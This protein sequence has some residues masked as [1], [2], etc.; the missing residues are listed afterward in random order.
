MRPDHER[1]APTHTRGAAPPTGSVYIYS[2][3]WRGSSGVRESR[4]LT[5][6]GSDN[7]L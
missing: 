6:K 4:I 3:Y 1:L 5:I 2:S 7:H